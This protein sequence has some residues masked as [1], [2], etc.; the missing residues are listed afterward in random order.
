MTIA[1]PTRACYRMIRYGLEAHLHPIIHR[2]GWTILLAQELKYLERVSSQA[3]EASDA[4][5]ES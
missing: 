5:I 1:S 3:S 4:F 2:H